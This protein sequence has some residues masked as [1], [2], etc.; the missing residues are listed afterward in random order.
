MATLF[1]QLHV[2]QQ[3][4]SAMKPE[5]TLGTELL[6]LMVYVG[7]EGGINSLGEQLY[8]HYQEAYKK[9][10]TPSERLCLALDKQ[11]EVS[12]TS[13]Q[14][15]KASLGTT[16]TFKEIDEEKLFSSTE[17]ENELEAYALLSASGTLVSVKDGKVCL[18][19][20]FENI[21][22]EKQRL[23][24][25]G[26]QHYTYK[27]KRPDS[28]SLLNATALTTELLVTF[29]HP[30]L[31]YLNLSRSG[32]TSIPSKIEG[33]S[34]KEL[35]LSG[36]TE[37]TSFEGSNYGFSRSLKLPDLEILH[38][39]NCSK[40]TSLQVEANHLKELKANNNPNLSRV[41]P[42]AGLKT[43]INIDGSPISLDEI[44]ESQYP[45][46]QAPLSD[47]F[48]SQLGEYLAGLLFDLSA[49]ARQKTFGQKLLDLLERKTGLEIKKYFLPDSSVLRIES[50]SDEVYIDEDLYETIYINIIGHKEAVALA[51]ILPKIPI[52]EL[53]LDEHMI[54]DSTMEVIALALQNSSVHHLYIGDGSGS[55]L[56]LKGATALFGCSQLLHVTFNHKNLLTTPTLIDKNRLK[57][58]IEY[59]SKRTG[60]DGISSTAQS[61]FNNAKIDFY[62]WRLEEIEKKRMAIRG[63]L[64]DEE[65]RRLSREE[66]L[67][68]RQLGELESDDDSSL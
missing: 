39:A 51:K 19:A 46:F 44:F 9:G 54:E 31:A 66:D 50:T 36:S 13:S 43:M 48:C 10:S 60:I 5:K 25:K 3:A 7:K 24:L 47:E 59:F 32:L 63:D 11:V 52:T 56:G 26:L 6:K 65:L 42:D 16:P 17:L 37:L 38:I 28:I 57:G 30:D 45:E 40:L 12:M 53:D 58:F 27:D 49:E 8:R 23:F 22:L 14:S 64:N 35:R 41:K 55:G 15:Q 61:I 62:R 67:L 33:C 29:F 4:L 2:I 21:S 1:A 34:L 68:I 20:D 18:E